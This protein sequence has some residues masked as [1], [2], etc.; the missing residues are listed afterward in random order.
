MFEGAH[1]ALIT[2]FLDGKVDESSLRDL[3]DFQF[4]NGISGIVP[5]GTTG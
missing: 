4:D 3:I 2:P 1:T 5:C